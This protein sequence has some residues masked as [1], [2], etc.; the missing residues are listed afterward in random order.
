MGAQYVQ[1][2]ENRSHVAR[3][4]TTNIRP[5]SKQILRSSSENFIAPPKLPDMSISSGNPQDNSGALDNFSKRP[6]CWFTNLV[7]INKENWWNAN[8]DEHSRIL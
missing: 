8:Y 5:I 2:H 4:A 1:P 7:K 3:E 6:S